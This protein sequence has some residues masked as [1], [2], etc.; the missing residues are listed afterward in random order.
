MSGGVSY[1]NMDEQDIQDVSNL[2][3]IPVHPV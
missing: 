1:S 2:G 3:A